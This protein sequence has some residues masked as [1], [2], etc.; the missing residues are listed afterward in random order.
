[1][2]NKKQIFD[3]LNQDPLRNIVLLKMLATE[4]RGVEMNYFENGRSAGVLMVLPSDHFTYDAQ[5]YP[6]VDYIVIISAD[7]PDVIA[8]MLPYI[9]RDKDIIFKLFTDDAFDVL[10]QHLELD[11]QRGFI[12]FSCAADAHFEKRPDVTLF[13]ELD[14]RLLPYFVEN[15]YTEAEVTQWFAE[16]KAIGFAILQGE[17]AKSVGMAYQNYGNIW[18]I[19]GLHTVH[20][21]RRGGN[22][23]KIV[24]TSLNI[25]LAAGKIPRYQI[26]EANIASRYLAE[27]IGLRPFLVTDHYLY[28]GK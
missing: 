24:E 5:T 3:Y 22:A 17:Q 1:M 9:P 6:D 14:E 20:S 10:S 8:E 19:G 7:A 4:E 27:K 16:Q 18:E 12:S 13:N 11:R 23:Q 21:A 2:N 25:L 28:K 26:H 15:G